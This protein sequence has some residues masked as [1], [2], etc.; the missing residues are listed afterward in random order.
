[1]KIYNKTGAEIRNIDF[2][3][4]GASIIYG[5]IEQPSKKKKTTNSIGKTLLLK[6][7]GYILGRKESKNDYSDKIIGWHLEAKILHK[8][9]E[10][11]IERTLGDS[12]SIT[13]DGQNYT[14]NN[15]IKYFDINAKQNS[16]QILLSRR[17]N[18]ISDINISPTKDDTMTILTLLK[19]NNVIDLFMDMRNIQEKVKAITDYSKKFKDTLQELKEKEFLLEQEKYKKEKELAELSNRINSL[20]IAKDSVELVELHS[21]KNYQLKNLK[22]EQEEIK[23]KIISLNELISEMENTDLSSK[24]VLKI[25]NIAKINIPEMVK[26]TID[27]VQMFYDN[28]F[29]DKIGKYTSDVEM[30]NQQVIKIQEQIN[31]LTPIVDDLASKISDNS[32][33][34]EAMNLYQL[35]NEELSQIERDYNQIVGSISNLLEKKNLQNDINQKYITLE[36]QMKQYDG[37]INEYRTYIYNLVN[38]IYGDDNKAYFDINV[39]SSTKRVESSPIVFDMNLIGEFGEGVRAVKNVLMDLLVFFYNNK[40]EFLIQDSACFEGIDTRQLSTL[41]SIINKTAIEINKQYILSIN[42]YHIDKTDEELQKLIQDR[43]IILLSEDDT[44]LKFRF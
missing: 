30:Y 27:E 43:N 18:I 40:I 4:S 2:N 22:I 9:K 17:Q 44:L 24:D 13:I 19:L 32:L 20:K 34:K 31:E 35:K 5:K 26:R 3:L 25:Y 33:F 12:S 10:Y 37:K 28:M 11:I 29:A 42:E 1:M 15:Y 36:E 16:K 8:N 6:F 38:E 23:A 39:S 41:I 7:I 21:E 14:Y